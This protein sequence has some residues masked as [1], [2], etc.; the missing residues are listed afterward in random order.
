MCQKF[1]F[2]IFKKAK[3]SVIDTRLEKVTQIIAAKEVDSNA[4]T[5]DLENEIDK[6]VYDLYDLTDD[7]IAI[8]EGRV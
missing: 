3:K 5:A 4:N 6:L 7:E 8:V 1:Q 2:Q